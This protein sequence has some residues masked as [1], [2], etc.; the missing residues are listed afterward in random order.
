LI[1]LG[2]CSF[3]ERQSSLTITFVGD[4]LLDRGVKQHIDHLGVD[5]LFHPGIDSLFHSSDVVI[6]NLECPA[7]NI[8]EPISKK[9]IFRADPD[10]L[11]A[12]KKHG[13]T[14][15]NMANNHSMDQ[16]RNGLVDTYNNIIDQG[17]IPI[18][19]AANYD[20]ACQPQLISSYPRK[21]YILSSLR[22]PSENWS[23]LKDKPCV[24]EASINE[25][26][27]SIKQLRHSNESAVIIVQ[28][29][30]GLEHTTEPLISQK[31]QAYQLIDAGADVIIG[32][33]THT[34]QT[35]EY[36]RGKPIYYS[37]GNFIF[38]QKKRINNKG[39]AV[40]MEITLNE[41]KFISHEFCIKKCSP[42]LID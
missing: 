18:G 40:K 7:T 23:F 19:Y 2:A 30:W 27:S 26:L 8:N 31:Q 5:H 12:L 39:L 32:H 17:L 16:G 4:L 22:V 37:I 42:Q 33:H 21:V 20:K 25:L 11:A 15:L 14:H 24:C 35:M 6:A 28:L 3:N 36:Y 13:I 34:I 9:Y 10:L 1:V 29:H 38:D 41:I